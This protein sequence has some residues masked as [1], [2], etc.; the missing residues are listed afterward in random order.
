[1]QARYITEDL[2][3]GLVPR[4]ELGRLV[5]VP[6]RVIDG[7]VSLGSSVCQED[8]WSTGRTLESLGLD[9]KTP[10][11]MMAGLAGDQEVRLLERS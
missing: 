2:P 7:I 6:T 9:G 8:Y 11:E 3:F 10:E 5:G 1:M 4:C